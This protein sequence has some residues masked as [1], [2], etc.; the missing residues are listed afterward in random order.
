MKGYIDALLLTVVR[1]RSRSSEEAL[2]LS[3]FI[4][5]WSAGFIVA[6]I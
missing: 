1:A 5:R 3:R 4:E 2:M 6:E